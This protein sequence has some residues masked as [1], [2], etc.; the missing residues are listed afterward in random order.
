[1]NH[2]P[3]RLPRPDASVLPLEATGIH[4]NVNVRR[5]IL[6]HEDR[7]RRNHCDEIHDAMFGR[8]RRNCESALWQQYKSDSEQHNQVDSFKKEARSNIIPQDT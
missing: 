6:C 3:D 4:R 2:G 1:M 8:Q 5:R 7:H